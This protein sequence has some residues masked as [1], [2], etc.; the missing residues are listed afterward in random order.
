MYIVMY[1]YVCMHVCMYVC[2]GNSLITLGHFAGAMWQ[3]LFLS[4]ELGFIV[5]IFILCIQYVS[6]YVRVYVCIYVFVYAYVHSR[7]VTYEFIY[8]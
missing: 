3:L 2:I 6:G 4:I 5:E 1:V 7:I 8:V